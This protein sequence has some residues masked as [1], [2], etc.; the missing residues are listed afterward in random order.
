[1]TN[2]Y[3][4]SLLLEPQ[5]GFAPAIASHFALYLWGHFL[6]SVAARLSEL[7]LPAVGDYALRCAV[8]TPKKV[9][10]SS[11]FLDLA[12]HRSQIMEQIQRRDLFFRGMEYFG[13]GSKVP[14]ARYVQEQV[15]KSDV[16]LG[17]YA[18]R[19]G[20]I[21]PE[22]GLSMTELEYDEAVRLKMPR[23]CYVARRD[24]SIHV[25]DVESDPEK[26]EKLQRF[27]TKVKGD[28]VYEFRD[29][30]DLARQV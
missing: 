19:Y 15:R 30:A 5:G 27:L 25:S 21:D 24:A 7:T 18:L 9:F 14:A 16:Y 26:M 13:A 23:L 2:G 20:S 1:V 28:V 22:T 10:V 6:A 8:S 12:E 17:V 3:A 4:L 29:I 11:T